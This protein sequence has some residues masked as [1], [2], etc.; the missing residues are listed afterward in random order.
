MTELKPCPFCGG[1]AVLDRLIPITR[2]LQYFVY[3]KSCAVESAGYPNRQLAIKAWNTRQ[4]QGIDWQ[5]IGKL[6]NR[7]ID[8]LLTRNDYEKPRF[9]THSLSLLDGEI[10]YLSQNYTHFAELT[11]PN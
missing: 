4:P 8:I 5:P 3:C 6:P 2:P 11:P 9:D 7:K 1:E 10:N